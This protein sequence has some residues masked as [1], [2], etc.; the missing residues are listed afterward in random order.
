MDTKNFLDE[1]REDI[2]RQYAT[3]IDTIEKE[4]RKKLDALQ[5]LSKPFSS[6]PLADAGV[7][8]ENRNTLL[9]SVPHRGENKAAKCRAALEAINGVVNVQVM[10]EQ[11]ENLYGRDVADDLSNTIRTF[12]WTSAKKGRL[13]ALP[14]GH[15]QMKDYMKSQ[16]K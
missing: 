11:I 13:S 8:Q 2:E 6:A 12:L 10:R 5:E 7:R 1:L 9:V 4:R 14:G 3:A 15:G 16:K